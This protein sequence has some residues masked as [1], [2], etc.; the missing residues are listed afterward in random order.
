M[1]SFW[2]RSLFSVLKFG[3]SFFLKSG[4][5]G[6]FDWSLTISWVEAQGSSGGV[7]LPFGCYWPV[8]LYGSTFF[9]Y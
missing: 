1:A 9:I 3:V 6:F 7:G 8:S 2:F 4:L 5:Q